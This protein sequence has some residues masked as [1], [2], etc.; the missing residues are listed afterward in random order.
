MKTIHMRILIVYIC[1]LRRT[2]NQLS[3]KTQ[4]NRHNLSIS[5]L[6]PDSENNV[7]L[8]QTIAMLAIVKIDCF[9]SIDLVTNKKI[10]YAITTIFQNK[11][12]K[13]SK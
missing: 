10:I 4:S 8:K 7:K 2:G 12:E 6:Y 5:T 1:R 13:S 3:R 9:M 11:H